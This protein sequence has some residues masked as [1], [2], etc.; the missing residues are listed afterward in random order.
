M[1][2]GAHGAGQSSWGPTVFALAR[3][4]PEAHALA[5]SIRDAFGDR[6]AWVAASRARNHGASCRSVP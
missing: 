2:R 3:G 6:L 4:E 5:D 1:A